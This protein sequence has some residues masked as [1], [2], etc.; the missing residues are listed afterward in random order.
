MYPVGDILKPSWSLNQ[1]GG[2]LMPNTSSSDDEYLVNKRPII[3][4]QRVGEYSF[5]QMADFKYNDCMYVVATKP[6]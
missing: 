6:M 1:M 2:Y 4:Y 5:P 3:K